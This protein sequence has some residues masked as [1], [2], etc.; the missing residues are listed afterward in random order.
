MA[1][2]GEPGVPEPHLLPPHVTTGKQTRKTAR[3]R[4]PESHPT[5]P[6]SSRFSPGWGWGAFI[7]FGNNGG[8]YVVSQPYS[9]FPNL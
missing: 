9:I 6:S 8:I 1:G 7:S 5:G 4:R 2:L 3:R